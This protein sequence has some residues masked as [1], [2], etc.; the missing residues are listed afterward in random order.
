MRGQQHKQE[1]RDEM[2][3]D[4]NVQKTRCETESRV[5]SNKHKLQGRRLRGLSACLVRTT[6][7]GRI[8]SDCTTCGS[9]LDIRSVSVIQDTELSDLCR[10]N[11]LELM[12]TFADFTPSMCRSDPSYTEDM[13]TQC[14]S[15]M[16]DFCKDEE[17][18]TDWLES[19]NVRT[20]TTRL[21]HQPLLTPPSSSPKTVT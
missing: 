2:Y 3:R 4:K 11:A 1:H 8:V 7:C 15:L 20:P 17:D 16:T 13:I 18:L 19:D 21:V 14:L 6:T 9:I 5:Q 12:A 10:Q